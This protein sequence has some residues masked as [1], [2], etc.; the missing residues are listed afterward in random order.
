[1]PIRSDSEPR[2]V[3]HYLLKN[4]LGIGEGIVAR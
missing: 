4:H 2:Q 3:Q 1:M